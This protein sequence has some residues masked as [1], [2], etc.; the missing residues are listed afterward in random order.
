[1]GHNLKELKLLIFFF[2]YFDLR[3]LS[4]VL[5]G[6][7]VTVFA[8]GPNVRWFKPG[9][10]PWILMVIKIPITTSFGVEVKPLAPRSNFLR[11]VKDPS[12]VRKRYSV[13]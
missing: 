6:L 9:Q 4:V 11:H 1:M 7:V 5:G 2:K 13:G 3:F 12:G 10:G 8:I